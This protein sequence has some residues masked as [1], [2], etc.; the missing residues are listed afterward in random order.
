ME[1][2]ETILIGDAL[3][4]A[5]A[6]DN[7]GEKKVEFYVDDELKKTITEKP[8]QWAWDE[9]VIGKHEIKAVAYD[10][11]DSKASDKIQIKIFNI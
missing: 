6:S 4:S 11:M 1:S 7:F 2:R 3:L 10:E 5:Y 8:Y 9:R